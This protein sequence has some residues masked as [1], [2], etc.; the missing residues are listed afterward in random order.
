MG[1]GK[2]V[3]GTLLIVLMMVSSIGLSGCNVGDL[4]GIVKS[5]FPPGISEITS[6]FGNL[7]GSMFSGG[8]TASPTS[9]I[10]SPVGGLE[11]PSDT[12]DASNVVDKSDSE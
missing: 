12:G 5:L 8:G 10:S 9:S 11:K 1:L 6:A 2:R 4:V 7:I 3:R